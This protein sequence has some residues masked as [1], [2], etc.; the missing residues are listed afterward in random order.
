MNETAYIYLK[1]ENMGEEEQEELI[2]KMD[3]MLLPLGLK[4]SG[5]QNM[6]IPQDSKKRDDIVFDAV[7]KLKTCDW[8]KGIY[9]F[10]ATGNKCFNKGLDV[11]DC[12]HMTLP[13]KSKMAYYEE[14]Y[15][16]THEFPHDIL[17]DENDCLADG[18]VSFLLAKKYNIKHNMYKGFSIY[19]VES[20]VPYKKVVIGRH[21]AF[22]KDNITIKSEK[23]YKWIY[24]I[25]SPVVPGD[26]LLVK[27]KKGKD[28]MVVDKISYDAGRKYLNQYKKVLKHTGK[29]MKTL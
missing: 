27:T 25:K 4:Y 13:K 11:I 2:S 16:M 8:L 7:H 21:V 23:Y 28:F 12:S 6:Y 3:D 19:Q 10:T 14:Y 15:L 17:V 18:Y 20:D 5:F 26:I 22:E 1:L 29:K 9:D 24:D